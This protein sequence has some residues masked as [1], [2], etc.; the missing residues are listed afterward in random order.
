M[1]NLASSAALDIP[2]CFLS[3]CPLGHTSIW[4]IVG[5]QMALDKNY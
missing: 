3:F 1:L 5:P 4:L 2:F